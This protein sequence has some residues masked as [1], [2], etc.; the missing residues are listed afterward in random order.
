[1]RQCRSEGPTTLTI[2]TIATPVARD[3]LSN[4][5]VSLSH[6]F[7]IS[8]QRTKT[9]MLY[10]ILVRISVY[11]IHAHVARTI[12]STRAMA[13]IKTLSSSPLISHRCHLSP[14]PKT[15]SIHLQGLVRIHAR[16]RTSSS[17]RSSASTPSTS[18]RQMLPVYPLTE[19]H[20]STCSRIGRRSHRA[21]KKTSYGT[22]LLQR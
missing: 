22:L 21:D 1:M 15:P 7:R 19:T 13:V 16:S 2:F 14:R 8:I 17:S 4:S 10:L 11:L 6:S 5:Y 20:R 12:C 3:N 9:S 18:S